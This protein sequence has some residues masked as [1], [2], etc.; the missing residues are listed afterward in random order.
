MPEGVIVAAPASGSGK[1]FVT[2]GLLRHFSERGVRC[3]SL[4]I[5]PD[6]I[7]PGFHASATGRPCYNLDPW[8]M[9]PET[10]GEAVRLAGD[11]ADIVV[12]EAVMGLF[13]GAVGD[14]GSS[15][16]VARISGWPVVLLLDAKAQGAS[17]SAVV[18]GFATHR[19][20]IAIAGVIFNR[21]GSAR[22]EK[23]LRQAMA[24]DLPKIPVLGCVPSDEAT[25]LP[26]RHL[27]LV[28]AME[29]A[30]L[31]TFIER[32]GAVVADHVDV[33]AVRALV[34]PWRGKT[35]ET[36]TQPLAPLGQK[37]AIARD[38]AFT[39]TYPLICEGW[40]RRGAELSFFSPLEDEAPNTDADAVF[41]P[42]GYPELHAWRLASAEQFLGGL[43]DAAARG[44]VI[45]GECGGYMVLGRGMVDADGTA[46]AMAGLLPLGTSFAERRLN[47]GYRRV[48]LIAETPL[49]QVGHRLRG[50]EF[51][52]A[53]ASNEGP[54]DALFDSVDA[55]GENR[56]RV[57]LVNGR[58]F[59]S[60]IHLIDKENR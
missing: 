32:A 47:L 8:A 26:S 34:R 54:G 3:G 12:C 57:G 59:G 29:H 38:E 37:I 20:D 60:F 28:Q 44:V 56:A 2:L 6:Y 51:H 4:K 55:H 7:D 21:V 22:H 46:H 18:R 24:R 27:G 52:Y 23:I 31:S 1:T 11:G 41:L 39:F 5:G 25:F 42:G 16:D 43:R 13:D 45:Y 14:L 10:V 33:A 36:R 17:V 15:A 58:V 30:D 35:P 48:K 49:G 40:R 19:D 50:H 53:T 9:R